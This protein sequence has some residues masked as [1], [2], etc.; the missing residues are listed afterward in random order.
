MQKTFNEYLRER[1]EESVRILLDKAHRANKLAKICSDRSRSVLYGVKY[2]HLSRGLELDNGESFCDS[3]V[4]HPVPLIG[5]TTKVGYRFHV[6]ASRLSNGA[7][8]ML[9][10]TNRGPVDA[11]TA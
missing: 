9:H 3:V 1:R 8:K 4:E 6:P 10:K 2:S 5:V 11:E 7:L